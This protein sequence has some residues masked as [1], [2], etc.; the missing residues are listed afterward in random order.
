MQVHFLDWSYFVKKGK[1]ITEEEKSTLQDKKYRLESNYNELYLIEDIKKGKKLRFKNFRT[2]I[3]P[4]DQKYIN[5][6]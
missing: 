4:Y 2:Y 3:D 5:L 1:E 6:I